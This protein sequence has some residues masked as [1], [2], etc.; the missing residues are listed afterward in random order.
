M[1]ARILILD[2]VKYS[3]DGQQVIYMAFAYDQNMVK[4]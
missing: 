3:E 1:A 2:I 4:T